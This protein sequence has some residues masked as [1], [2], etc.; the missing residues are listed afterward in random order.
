MKAPHAA[1]GEII[2][3]NGK[4]NIVRALSGAAKDEKRSKKY[5]HW[6]YY[7]DH[8]GINPETNR[9]M[10]RVKRPYR[11]ECT[12]RGRKYVICIP[13]GFITDLAS[14][15]QEVWSLY[16][17]Y[18]TYTLAAILHDYLTGTQLY[19]WKECDD[20]FYHAMKWVEPTTP[21]RTRMIFYHFVRAL[22]ESVVYKGHTR[23]K[24]AA[25]RLYQGYCR[26]EKAKKLG[27]D[28]CPFGKLGYCDIPE[29][30]IH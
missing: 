29:E 23:E 24:L 10:W 7:V 8:I 12:I 25:E 9:L 6:Q 5:K 1:L 28:P 15:P 3:K 22:G 26:P 11:Y 17:P 18:G 20:I 27:I 14:I 16:G 4:S 30:D 13:V 2:L 19:S 21:L